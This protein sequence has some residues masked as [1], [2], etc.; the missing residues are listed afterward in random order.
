MLGCRLWSAA[1]PAPYPARID[2]AQAS[3][4]SG[5]LA[6]KRFVGIVRHSAC[7]MGCDTQHVALR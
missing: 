7:R 1:V 5:L 2:E 3:K 6:R 4:Q